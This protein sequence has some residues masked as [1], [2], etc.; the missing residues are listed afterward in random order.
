MKLW[1]IFLVIAI[2]LPIFIILRYRAHK[3]AF[4]KNK[5]KGK[6]LANTLRVKTLP[7]YK[8]L[9]TVY[10]VLLA[11]IVMVFAVAFISGVFL[12]AR[13]YAT[14]LENP[15]LHSRDIV[16]CLDVSGS[17][18]AYNQ[19][20]VKQFREIT[21]G[22]KGERLGLMV[23]DTTAVPIFPLT[24]D[25]EF[26]LEQLERVE[27]GLEPFTFNE[28]TRYVTS[29]TYLAYGASFIGDGITSCIDSFDLLEDLERSRFIVLATDN[30]SGD[31]L[32]TVPQAAEYARSL[33]VR[34]YGINPSDFST[35]NFTYDSVDEYRWATLHTDGAYYKAANKEA[36][37][38]IV[39]QIL[40]QDAIQFV[41]SPQLIETD[42]PL[43]A[44]IV[45]SVSFC[46]FVVLTWRLR[47]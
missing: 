7:A 34:L 14:S 44:F 45:L 18:M 6:P 17:M 25:Y 12:S 20:I 2:S 27:R 31:S 24:D 39:N 28:D 37:P 23:F 8:R 11:A 1:W 13:P 32:I 30:Y 15:T 4:E 22:L 46:A 19:A 40:A 9:M 33:G 47:I 38:D 21:E 29:G 26:I 42:A 35:E 16:L 36:V 43:V 5:L 41:G 10:R 3:K